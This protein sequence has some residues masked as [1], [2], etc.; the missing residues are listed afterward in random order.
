LNI[1]FGA[2]NTMY[3]QL[4]NKIPQNIINLIG[5]YK[6]KCNTCSNS[7]VIQN[8]T[9]KTSTQFQLTPYTY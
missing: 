9:S 5:I 4:S 7:Y 6:L 8:G 1:A 3:K 2:T